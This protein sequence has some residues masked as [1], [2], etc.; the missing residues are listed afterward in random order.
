MAPA[1]QYWLMKSEP[2]AFSIDDLQ[3]AP[4]RTT[5]WDG[6]RNYQARNYM[7]QMR[8]GDQILFHH[9]NADTMDKVSQHS[10]EVVGRTILL[11]VELLDAAK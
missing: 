7:R 3:R 8:L 11:T 4:R 10:L 9:S 2:S 1:R 5:C 6:V